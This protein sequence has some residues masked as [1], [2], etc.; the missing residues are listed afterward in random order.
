MLG[1]ERIYL[2][3][4]RP[5]EDEDVKDAPGDA[6]ADLVLSNH[7]IHSVRVEE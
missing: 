6:P 1:K 5:W 4:V 7:R 3:R 2:H